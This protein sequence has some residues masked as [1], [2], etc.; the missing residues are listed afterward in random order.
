MSDKTSICPKCG[1]QEFIDE[2]PLKLALTDSFLEGSK[3]GLEQAKKILNDENYWLNEEQILKDC[4][5]FIEKLVEK[6]I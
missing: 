1:H 4:A 5:P 6:H 3:F 2:A